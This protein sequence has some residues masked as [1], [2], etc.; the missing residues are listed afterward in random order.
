MHVR[1]STLL[2]ELDVAVSRAPVTWVVGLPGAGKTSAVAAWVRESTRPCAWYRLDESDADP[3]GWFDALASAENGHPLLPAWSPD[4]ELTSFSRQFF[5]TLG[6]APLT[7]V[8][9]DCHRVADDSALLEV[10]AQMHEL[11]GETLKL[12]VVSRRAPP[13]ALARGAFQ[14]RLAMVDGLRVSDDEA[15][16]IVDAHHRRTPTAE[17]LKAAD[18]WLAHL[19]ASSGRSSPVAIDDLGDFLAAEILAS[20]PSEAERFALK[21][22]AELPEIPVARTDD[23]L[24]PDEVAGLLDSLAAQ[25][26]FVDRLADRWR[27]HDL[28][29]EGLLASP[30]D[31]E[32]TRA[33]ARW[34]RPA[35]PEAAMPLFARLGDSEALA[36]LLALHGQAWLNSGL[37]RTLLEWLRETDSADPRLAFWKAQALLPTEPEAA[38]PLFAR[39][40]ARSVEARW[41]ELAVD[42]WCGEVSSY[43]VQWGAVA[44]LA[45]L[46]DE[47]ER[48]ETVLGPITGEH[49][50]RAH[51][52]ALTALMYGRAEDERLFRYAEATRADVEH[53]PD[54]DARISA[55]AQLLIFDL[56]W[57]GDFPRGRVLYDTFDAEV[58]NDTSLGTLPKLLWWSN[59]SIIDWQAGRAE[60]CY[61]KV[62]AGLALA[63]ASGVH[64]RDFFLLTQG[65]FCAISQEDWPRAERYLDQLARTE[66]T[67]KRLDSMVHHFFRSWYAL[68]RGDASTALA[69]AE[70]AW[71]VSQGLGSMFHQVIALSA[72]LPARV[73]TGDFAGAEQAYRAQVAM[74]K[75]AGNPTFAYIAFCG[76]AELAEA[77]NDEAILT[78]QIDRM[79]QVKQLGGFHSHCGWR[80]PM[81]QRLL[82]FALRKSIHVDVAVQWIREKR[83][84]PPLDPPDAWPR[85]VRIRA[86]SGL[87]VKI[88]GEGP[89]ASGVR[90]A[91]KLRELLAVLVAQRNGAT[92]ADLCDWLWPDA[93]GD[94]AQQSLKQAVHRLRQWL[95]TDAVKVQAQ[96][97]RLE[98]AF[99]DCD[100]W[101]WNGD[102]EAAEQV[103]YGYDLEPIRAFR[104]RLTRA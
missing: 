58:W 16:A 60:D 25:R 64:V 50:F 27:L 46:V 97:V 88:E 23:T 87:E 55:A 31:A 41:L 35:M 86:A 26:Y 47:L 79:L 49:A 71:P 32:R 45:D 95:G 91:Q 22:L 59:A 40:R 57:A 52:H 5:G 98:P 44:G 68:C 66:R 93:E 103:L 10:L 54:A 24:L 80:T 56:W 62:E 100:V 39:A 7:L 28:L 1:R 104:S 3:A 15:R 33:L 17:V 30:R 81:M 42:A 63:Q 38:R 74:A 14:G 21:A 94:K 12:V 9:D 92:Q 13:P 101:R 34:V 72:L 70:T 75:A 90:A 37:H 69:H 85:P 89:D 65:I 82:A 77:R 43:V 76:G 53:T 11:C 61:R 2:A 29:R 18:G 20:L 96:S 83:I 6:S 36:A 73:A 51:A 4:L 78:K 19:L 84:P 99:I 67:H 102:A 48:I 8:I